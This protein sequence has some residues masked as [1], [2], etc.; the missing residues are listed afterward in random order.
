[1]IRFTGFVGVS[2]SLRLVAQA[3]PR[4]GCR[5]ADEQ[6]VNFARVAWSVTRAS[7]HVPFQTT[8]LIESLAAASM[9]WRRGCACNVRFGV[10]RSARHS[11]AA[12]A[13]V[14]CNGRVVYGVAADC[15]EYS[16]LSPIVRISGRALP[17]GEVRNVRSERNA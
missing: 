4:V 17:S 10:R 8:C 12:H 14:E 2:A 1:M 15:S 11:L 9:L 13:W 7:R 3:V 6:S 16:V 5:Y